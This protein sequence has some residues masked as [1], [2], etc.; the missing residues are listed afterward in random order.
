MT[1]ELEAKIDYVESM[2]DELCDEFYPLED[3]V[4]QLE[5]EIVNLNLKLSR[6]H[7]NLMADDES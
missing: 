6:L 2:V 4:K 3:R 7:N 1:L 5:E